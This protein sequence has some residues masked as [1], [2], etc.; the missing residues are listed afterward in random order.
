MIKQITIVVILGLTLVLATAVHL[1][2][3]RCM[4]L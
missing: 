4:L 3:I 1:Q 2:L